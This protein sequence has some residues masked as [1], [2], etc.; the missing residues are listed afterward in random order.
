M[1]KNLHVCPNCCRLEVVYDVISGRDVNSIEGYPVAN[2]EVASCNI[3]RDIKKNHFVTAAAAG[4]DD[5]IRRKRIH[6]SLRKALKK[7]FVTY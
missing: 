5:S 4:I 2:F 3:F 1:T 7:K 6:V